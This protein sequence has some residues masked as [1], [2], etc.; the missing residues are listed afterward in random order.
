MLSLIHG[1]ATDKYKGVFASIAKFFLWL[2]SLVYCFLVKVSAGFYSISPRRLKCKVISVGNITLGG[3]GKTTLVEY[4]ARYL[5]GQGRKVAVL[6]RGYAKSADGHLKMGDEPY[7]LTKKLGDIPVL[8]G[9]DRIQS[10]RL[11][12]ESYGVDTVILDDGFQQWR[13]KKD[14]EIVAVNSGLPFGNLNCI[15]RGILREPL[16]SLGRAS[17]FVLTKINPGTDTNSIKS[18]LQRFNPRALVFETTHKAVGF[19]NLDNPERVIGAESLKD[20]HLAL[21]SGIGD[22]HSFDNLIRSLGLKIGLSFRFRDHHI[23]TQEDLERI[24]RSC[25]KRSIDTIIT[26]EKDAPRL[27][28]LNLDRQGFSIFVLRIELEFL[29]DEQ[30]FRDRLLKLYSL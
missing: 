18:Q 20:K 15:P 27:K 16:S 24:F 14:L 26:T 1:L 7:M 21:F 2:L 6:S 29:K 10:A 19:I 9:P 13:I 3:T 25:E 4:I 12:V 23:Y 17:V 30:G 8:V 11:A 28:D 5:K 22:P